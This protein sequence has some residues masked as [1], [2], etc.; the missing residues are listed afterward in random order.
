MNRRHEKAMTPRGK[1]L[2]KGK[3]PAKP[4]GVEKPQ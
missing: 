1:L 4:K 3:P 2:F